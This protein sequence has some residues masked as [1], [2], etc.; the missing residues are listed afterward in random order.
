MLGIGTFDDVVVGIDHHA[1]P[2]AVT[3]IGHVGIDELVERIR[4]EGLPGQHGRSPRNTLKW[5]C[6]VRPSYQPG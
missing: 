3:I 2:G 5:I 6:V 1:L 4:Q